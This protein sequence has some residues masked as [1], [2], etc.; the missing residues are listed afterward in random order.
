L[1]DQY[2]KKN[3]LLTFFSPSGYLNVKPNNIRIKKHYIPLDTISNAKE[4][5]KVTHPCIAIFAKYDFWFNHLTELQKSAIPIIVFS[6]N[7]HQKQLY[8]KAGW[9]WQKKILQGISRI[10][11][12]NNAIEDFLKTEKFQNVLTCGDT[13]FDE[14]GIEK[15]LSLSLISNYIN[16]RTCI[17]VGS[18]WEAEE[19]ILMKTHLKLK[20]FAIIIAP[21]DVS[22]KR[23]NSIEKHFK[24]KTI[25]FSQ[26][27]NDNANTSKIL[28]IDSIGV[29]SEIYHY[30]DI[31]F[32]GGGFKGKLHNILEPAATNNVVLF[33]N[34]Y[35]K[36]EE[37]IELIKIK[38]AFKINNDLDFIE[39]LK[40]LE[41]EQEMKQYK[42]T[43][44]N[45]VANNKGATK[46]VL[47]EI[48]KL[49]SHSTTSASSKI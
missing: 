6:S 45:Y 30:S 34:K 44:F 20:N 33:G 17:V 14:V 11:V 12:L 1:L 5:I 48:K 36:Y 23:I 8:F 41:N 32:I 16:K 13:R 28:L 22:E 29:L 10:L 35:A 39:T 21:H 19:K 49:M 46:I 3:I 42:E 25:R 26:L 47:N 37:A 2:P 24:N 4:F 31:A 40:R 18:S 43:A 27:N 9:Q 38:G 7:L 15:K